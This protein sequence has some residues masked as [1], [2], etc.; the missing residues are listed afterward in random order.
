MAWTARL[1]YDPSI[2]RSRLR[3]FERQSE[4]PRVRQAPHRAGSLD[5]LLFPT[6]SIGK[7]DGPPK[8]GSIA[9]VARQDKTRARVLGDGT[10]IRRPEP[11]AGYYL[12][13]TDHAVHHR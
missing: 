2:V 1:Q 6:P 13:V 5:P 12:V 8:P 4:L 9:P 11:G 7:G 3:S 10:K